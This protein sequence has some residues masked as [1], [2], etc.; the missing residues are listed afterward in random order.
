[1]IYIPF[2]ST[3][4]WANTFA[5]RFGINS[6]RHNIVSYKYFGAVYWWAIKKLRNEHKT[7]QWIKEETILD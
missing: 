1:M 5:Y 6:N 2:T 3:D 7:N 4:I